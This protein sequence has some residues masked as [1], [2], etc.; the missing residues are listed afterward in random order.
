MV[1][2]RP[3]RAVPGAATT[4]QIESPA[5]VWRPRLQVPRPLRQVQPIGTLA[6]QPVLELPGDRAAGLNHAWPCSAFRDVGRTITR[7]IWANESQGRARFIAVVAPVAAVQ[8]P[9]S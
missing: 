6:A 4:K 2:R 9:P 8:V 1:I 5:G 7:T 3:H